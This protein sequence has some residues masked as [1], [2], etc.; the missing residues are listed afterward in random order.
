MDIPQ[1]LIEKKKEIKNNNDTNGFRDR[2]KFLLSA[3]NNIICER[4]FNIRGF[5]SRCLGSLD[6]KRCIDGIVEMIQND[7]TSKSRIDMWYTTTTPVKLTGFDKNNKETYLEYDTSKD[8][9]QYP[10]DEPYSYTFKFTLEMASTMR[11]DANGRHVYSDYKPVYDA[12]WD[13]SQYPR[14]VRNHVDLTNSD[15]SFRYKDQNNLRFRDE[16]QKHMV[17]GKADLVKAI[18]QKFYDYTTFDENEDEEYTTTITIN[19]SDKSLP[20][21]TYRLHDY[22]KA[23]EDDWRRI[24]AKKT[25]EYKKSWR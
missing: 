3:N 18:I 6:L 19:H 22:N 13:G 20:P 25:E 10:M 14:S 12:I 7:L 2:F 8:A 11:D 24:T 5:N 9:P 1:E 17:D 23:V 21:T 15:F 16:L 4:Y